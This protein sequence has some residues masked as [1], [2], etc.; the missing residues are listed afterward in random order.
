[1]QTIRTIIGRLIAEWLRGVVELEDQGQCYWPVANS[2]RA[3]IEF[4]VLKPS[5]QHSLDQNA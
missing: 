4:L 5:L 3:S 1:M 2:R